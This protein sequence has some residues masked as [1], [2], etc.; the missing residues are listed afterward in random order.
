VLLDALSGLGLLEKKNNRYQ[1]APAVVPFLTSTGSHAVLPMVMHA[2]KLW[3]TWSG[4]TDIARGTRSL[5]KAT[6]YTRSENELQ[7]FIGAMHVVN[8]GLAPK[9]V[10]IVNPGDARALLDVGGGPGTYTL[11]FLQASSSLRA[12]LF[13]QPAVVELARPRIEAA[14]QL[15]RVTF[16]P[17][18]F[19]QNELPAGHDLAFLSAIIHQNS[20]EQNVDLYR[21]IFNALL[22]GGR[23]VI[24]DHIMQADRTH[25]VAG[26]MFAINMLVGTIGGGTYTYPEIA[27]GLKQAGFERIRLIQEGEQMDGLVEAYRP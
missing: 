20:F 3:K 8:I 12:T 5:D 25:P 21:K 17:G 15:H 4:L 6:A 18:D 19:Y 1:T 9:I 11:A 7:A 26:A 14:G 23:L 16:A 24:R 2:A 22:P 27:E 10:A 13:D